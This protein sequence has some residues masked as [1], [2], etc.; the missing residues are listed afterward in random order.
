MLSFLLTKLFLEYAFWTGLFA[1]I[2]EALLLGLFIGETL[3]LVLLPSV[4]LLS[5]LGLDSNGAYCFLDGEVAMICRSEAAIL[6]FDSLRLF[7]APVT[8]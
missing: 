4:C 2:W 3:L 8:L 7:V 6:A 1:A 5:R